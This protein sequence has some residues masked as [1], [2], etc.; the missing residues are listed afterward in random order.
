MKRGSSKILVAIGSRGHPPA[1]VTCEV[2]EFLK[3]RPNFDFRQIGQKSHSGPAPPPKTE[4]FRPKTENLFL[5]NCFS[6]RSET[7]RK[8][9]FSIFDDRVVHIIGRNRPKSAIFDSEKGPQLGGPPFFS[10][11]SHKI[12]FIPVENRKSVFAE[13]F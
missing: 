5:G 4:F 11:L 13:S 3:N 7:I 1:A 12:F 9:R 2:G 8:N 10:R 6:R